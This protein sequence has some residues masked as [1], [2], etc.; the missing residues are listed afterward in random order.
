M[1]GRAILFAASIGGGLLVLTQATWGE[2]QE[3]AHERTAAPG[4]GIENTTPYRD[5]R[6][7]P[8][9]S[10]WSEIRQPLHRALV[11]SDSVVQRTPSYW[12]EGALVGG[13]VS[14]AGFWIA[15]RLAF[16]DEPLQVSLGA[17]VGFSIAAAFPGVVIGGLIGSTVP[18]KD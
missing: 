14:A 11:Q 9:A 18:K 10:P 1:F 16:P 4:V 7:V 2:A 8:P 6:L 5:M 15:L 17:A 3:T 13:I 12:I